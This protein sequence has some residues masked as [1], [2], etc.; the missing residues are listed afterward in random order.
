[1]KSTYS[2]ALGPIPKVTLT[3]TSA[4]F[5]E[6]MDYRGWVAAGR[7]LGQLAGASLFWIGDWIEFAAGKMGE[8]TSQRDVPTDGGDPSW[9]KYADALEVTGLEYDTLRAIAWVARHVAVPQRRPELTFQHH[10]EVAGLPVKEQKKWLAR[11]VN[12]GPVNNDSRDLTITATGKRW[13]VSELRQAIRQ[14]NGVQA[15]PAEPDPGLMKWARPAEDLT[16]YLKAEDAQEPIEQWTTEKKTAVR[17]ALKETKEIIDR[18]W[19][20]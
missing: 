12:G 11:A 19:A 10:R 1:M 6:G 13:T 18:I 7:Q 14:A 17:T 8:R 9:S 15:S 4:E 3:V 16:R 20:G 2:I 5:D